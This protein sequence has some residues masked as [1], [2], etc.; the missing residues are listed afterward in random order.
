MTSFY[1]QDEFQVRPSLALIAGLRHDHYSTVGSGTT[2]RAAIVFNPSPS[3]TAK[4]LYGQA[5]RA[6]S[7][8]ETRYG[9]GANPDLEAEQIE[10]IEAVWEQ[11]LGSSLFGTVSLYQSRFTN[12]IDEIVLTDGEE[13]QF[14]NVGTAL[15]RGAELGLT[16]RFAGGLSGHASYAYQK[17]NDGRNRAELTNSPDQAFKLGLSCPLVGPLR[18]SG[19][20]LYETGRLTV[21]DTR[22]SSYFLSNLT[23][24]A[25]AGGLPVRSSLSPHL[26]TSRRLPGGFEHRQAD[27]PGRRNY[28]L[29]SSTDFDQS[30]TGA[31]S[32]AFAPLCG[33]ARPPFCRHRHTCE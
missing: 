11:R 4:L 32:G 30:T 3:S 19:E 33:D 21:R 1:V 14:Q 26:L 15:A 23:L 24:S 5:F 31:A 25:A 10:T 18:I 8:Y 22:T 29:S 28:A 16:A 20:L 9:R 12:L 7:I 6:P 27:P 17:A 13:T 2:P